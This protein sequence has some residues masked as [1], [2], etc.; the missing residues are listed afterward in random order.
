MAMCP[1]FSLSWSP[2]KEREMP[3]ISRRTMLGAVGASAV[4]AATLP[5]NARPQMKSSATYKL[6]RE[7]PVEE[8]YDLVVAGGGPAGA[9]A[10]ISAARLGAKVLLAEATG[11]M[12]G[13]GTSGLVTQFPS[14][15]D[16]ERTLVGGVLR[17]ITE[18]MY[19]GGFIDPHIGPETWHKNGVPHNVEGYKLTLDE[20]ASK[21]G[22]EV[23][24]F[25]HVIDVDADAQAGQIHGIILSNIEGYRY[26][27]AKTFVDATG[28]AVLSALCG[29]VCREAGRDTPGIMPPSLCSMV[30]S[31]AWD[32]FKDQQKM[33]EKA[34]DDGFFSVPDRHV[35]GL[36]RVGEKIGLL[37]APHVFNLNALRCKSLTD[38]VMAGRRLAQEYIAFYRKYV[39]GC[40]NLEHVTTA[41]LMGV[42]ESRRILGEYEMTAND[43]LS[44]RVFPD[45][46]GVYAYPMDPHPYDNS[47][48]EYERY[49][50]EFTQTGKLKT[51]EFYGLPYGIL[52]PKGWKNLWAAGRCVSTDLR[53]NSAIRVQPAAFLMG[54]AAG[55]AAV[56]SIRTK[57]PAAEI[58]TEVL[59][60][61]LRK[62]GA[63][64]PQTTTSKT[65]TLAA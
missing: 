44:L 14:F 12:G 40:E 59:V 5:G 15:G 21:A 24:F 37:N 10:A 38:G 25:T 47:K 16:G 29:A 8:G 65:L 45:Q 35:P 49:Y 33:V 23:C 62:A 52:V 58:D 46:I 54:Q 34:I 22:V 36:F 42:R 57:R 41:D 27:R 30:A 20:F 6:V 13:M 48:A 19:Q 64:L 28:D 4:A 51:G 3:R 9:A 2:A 31:V 43:F 50:R 39:P 61:T 60:N 18:A 17:E 26:V 63:Y 53:V 55:T 11:C 7:I 56:Q 1:C 32:R